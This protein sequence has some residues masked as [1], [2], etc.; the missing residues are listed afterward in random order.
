[1]PENASQCEHVRPDGRRCRARARAHS[2]YCFAHDPDLAARRAAGRRAGGRKRSQKAAV[3]PAGTPDAPLGSIGQ[4]CE[5]LATSINQVRRGQLDT[6]VANA[7]GYLASVL[8]K[9]LSESDMEAR[10]NRLE[11]LLKGQGP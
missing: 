9:A 6:K 11:E 4:V 2:R 5:L 7:V 3:L 10:I 1:M 8:V